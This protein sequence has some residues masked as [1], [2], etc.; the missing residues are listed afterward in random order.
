ML[1]GGIVSSPRDS[2]SPLQALELA[3]VYLENAIK[4][5]DPYVALVF[6][7]DTEVSL[8][9]AKKNSKRNGIQ[10]VRKGIANTYIGLGKQL[11]SRGRHREATVSYK[12]AEKLG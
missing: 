8:S 9:L 7:H 12:K 4:A 5:K 10:A 1:F 2:L 6:C 3:N 11:D